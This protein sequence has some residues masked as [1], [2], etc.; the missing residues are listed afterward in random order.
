MINPTGDLED[1]VDINIYKHN[2]RIVIRQLQRVCTVTDIYLLLK[3]NQNTSF[4]DV[5]HKFLMSLTF[6]KTGAVAL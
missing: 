5:S 6:H 4:F 1:K 2:I 3:Q